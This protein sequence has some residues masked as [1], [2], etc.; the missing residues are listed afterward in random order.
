MKKMV[1]MIA[2]AVMAVMMTVPAFAAVSESQARD[3]ALKKAG[4][5]ARDVRYMQ[6]EEDWDDGRQKYEVQFYDG[7]AE[8]ECGVDAATGM[9]TGFDID[10]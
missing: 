6:V 9:V 5:D 10:F 4:I 1:S 2:A 8:Y 7:R 3:I